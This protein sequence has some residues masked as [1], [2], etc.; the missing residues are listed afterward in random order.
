MWTS[1]LVPALSGNSDDLQ[2]WITG[3]GIR[4]DFHSESVPMAL[5]SIVVRGMLVSFLHTHNASTCIREC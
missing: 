4:F 2:Y 3:T 5:H 1:Q